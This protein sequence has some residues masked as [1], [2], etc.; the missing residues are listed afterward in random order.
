M[1]WPFPS[2]RLHGCEEELQLAYC[3]AVA[4]EH[5]QQLHQQVRNYLEMKNPIILDKTT[6]SYNIITKTSFEPGVNC[7]SHIGISN[8]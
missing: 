1:P 3:D 6:Q 8:M 7:S 5:A 2:H 4:G